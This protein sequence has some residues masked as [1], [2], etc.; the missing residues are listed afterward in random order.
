MSNRL[1]LDVRNLILG[2]L[3]LVNA[4]GVKAGIRCNLQVKPLPLPLNIFLDIAES[5]YQRLYDGCVYITF[6]TFVDWTD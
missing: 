5:V 6:I 4:Y 3:H 1:Q 2:R